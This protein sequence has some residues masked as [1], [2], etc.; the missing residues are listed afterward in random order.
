MNVSIF[1]FFNHF[2]RQRNP[3]P[4]SIHILH[5]KNVLNYIRPKKKC[6][7]F[8]MA[9]PLDKTKLSKSNKLFFFFQ[10]R[11]VPLFIYLFIYVPRNCSFKDAHQ[12]CFL[13]H[14]W[15]LFAAS[16]FYVV[17]FFILQRTEW[18]AGLMVGCCHTFLS[19][20]VMIICHSS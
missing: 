19:R 13:V 9:Q 14:V 15:P 2:L 4:I 10:C 16:Y 12:L 7:W 18:K 20:L 1:I 3:W 11:S 6:S 17:Y 8:Y 5:W